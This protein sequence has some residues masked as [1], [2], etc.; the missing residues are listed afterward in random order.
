[1]NPKQKGV[2]AGYH[3]GSG[4]ITPPYELLQL[5]AR[6]AWLQGWSLGVKLRERHREELMAMVEAVATSEVTP[7]PLAWL[8]GENKP[9]GLDFTPI[10]QRRWEVMKREL[11][12]KQRK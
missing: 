3:Y 7:S 10:D 8:A 11:Q 2:K 9:D 5:E 6:R 12:R 4:D 1:M